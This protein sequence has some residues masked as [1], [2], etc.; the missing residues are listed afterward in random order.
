MDH[1]RDNDITRAAIKATNLTFEE[2]L[3]DVE[4]TLGEPNRPEQWPIT[5][6][7]NKIGPECLPDIH[8][9]AVLVWLYKQEVRDWPDHQEAAWRYVNKAEYA[10]SF[11]EAKRGKVNGANST[12][13]KYE[14]SREHAK[15]S[16]K[17]LIDADQDHSLRKKTVIEEVSK[18][19]INARLYSP[20]ERTLWKWLTTANVIPA[21]MTRGGRPRKT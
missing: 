17:E 18:R 1:L 6:T 19:L 8:P 10:S 11:I 13:A 4:L 21:Y 20:D 9:F 15:V 3:D 5:W 12:N 16:A 7:T 14:K 2:L